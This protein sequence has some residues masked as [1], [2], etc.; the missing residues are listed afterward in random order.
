MSAA[1]RRCARSAPFPRSP[2]AAAPPA[3]PPPPRSPP[4]RTHKKNHAHRQPQP[5]L[6]RARAQRQVRRRLQRLVPG[7]P[8]ALA[9]RPRRV[10]ARREEALPQVFHGQRPR[11][12][13]RLGRAAHR[14]AARRA[15]RP[16]AADVAHVLQHAAAAGLRVAGQDGGPAAAGD[17]QRRGLWARVR[18]RRRRRAAN[19]R[20]RR[21]WRR[22]GGWWF[23]FAVSFCFV[24]TTPLPQIR[25][26]SPSRDTHTRAHAH[27]H[28]HTHPRQRRVLI[29]R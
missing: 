1:P 13:R 22:E 2:R 18:A 8:V 16:Q 29:D 23:V 17:H 24:S 7:L 14:R 26:T 5:R 28:R 15:R 21:R 6:R 27:T 25:R 19:A 20:R 12:D 3:A 10:H 11:A 4:P 9:H